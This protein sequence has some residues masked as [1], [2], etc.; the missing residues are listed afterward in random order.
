MIAVQNLSKSYGNLEVIKD[1]TTTIDKGEIITIIGPSGTGKSTFLRCLNMLEHPTGGTIDF[2]GQNLMDKKT[3]INNVRKKMGMVF[4]NFNLFAHM[5]VLDNLC[6]GQTKL[7]GIT[8]DEAE[9][10]AR[11]LLQTVGLAEKADAYP[12]QLSG[13]Q[14]QRV[15]IARC[16]S[17]NPDIM[18]F[19]EPTS[20]LDPTMVGEVTA[21]IRRLAQSGMTMAI[22]THEMEFAKNVST[23]IMYLD[24][25]GIYEEGPPEVIFNNPKRE[26]TR[27]FIKRIKRFHYEIS[28]EDFDFIELTNNLLNFCAANALLK[29]NTN[30]AGLLSE[31]LTVNLIP[32]ADLLSVDFSFP[33]SQTEFEFTVTYGGEDRDVTQSDDMAA[34]IVTGIINEKTHEYDGVNRLRLKW[35]VDNGK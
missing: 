19:D 24:E 1:I 6:V 29:I 33:D 26:K 7:L 13:G 2:E 21:V 20:A 10:T 30:K 5:S 16:L 12:D 27:A 11:E 35:G 17:M 34:T 18:L 22:V 23:R 31:E 25:G 9:K 8:R 4:Q 32:K 14:K 3:N 28:S 15:A